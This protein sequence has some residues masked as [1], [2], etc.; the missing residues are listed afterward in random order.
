MPAGL[1]A[2]PPYPPSELN[3]CALAEL[4]E[5]A[6]LMTSTRTPMMTDRSNV[7]MV[8]P[9]TEP[10]DMSRMPKPSAIYAAKS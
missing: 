5:R 2:D 1:T 8:P 10:V 7:R 6:G 9:P 3:P 4:E